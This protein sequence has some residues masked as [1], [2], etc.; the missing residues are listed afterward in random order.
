M[1]PSNNAIDVKGPESP[2]TRVAVGLPLPMAGVYDYLV[3]SDISVK[4][5]DLVTVPFGPRKLTGVVWSFRDLDVDDL[6]LDKLKYIDCQLDCSALD[7]AILK[8]VEWVAAYTLSPQG[9]ILR[10]V[11]SVPDATEAPKQK[12]DYA[13]ASSFS[14]EA[15]DLRKTAARE[16]VVALMTEQ[17]QLPQKDI[18]RRAGVGASVVKSLVKAGALEAKLRP[19]TKAFH[20][21]SPDLSGPTLAPEQDTAAGK[22]VS[23]VED[24]KFS[25]TVLDG[26]TGSGK[27][28]V[29]FEAIAAAL[30]QG[31]QVMVLLPEI[32]LTSQWLDRF[33]Q[34][35][36]VMPA[37]WHSDLNGRER[38]QC[39]RAV[40]SGEV[41]VLVGAR[42]ALFLPFPKLG[43]IIIDEEH[44]QAFKQ[45]DGVRY[46][47]RDMSV[48][49]AKQSKCPLILSSATPSMES[50][51][52]VNHGRYIRVILPR[53]FAGAKP[54]KIIPLDL[55][56]D[57]PDRGAWLAP[58]LVEAIK[59]ATERGEQSLLFLNRR[60][61]APLTLCRSCGH[62][63]ECPSCSAWLVEHRLLKKLQCHHCGYGLPLPEACPKCEEKQSLVPCG[64]G[65]ER[66]AEEVSLRFPEARA[67]VV[68]SDTVRGPVAAA[69]FVSIVER[70][71][72]D[73]L[74]GTQLISKGY[75]F[76][77]LTV[78]G[79]VDADLGL[80]GGDFRASERSFQLLQ[81]VAGRA[82]RD[83]EHPG[84]VF[85]QTH[86]PNHPVM[87]ALAANDRDAFYAA[88]A[89][90][91]AEA[92]MPP[93]GRMAALILSDTKESSVDEACA[94]LARDAPNGKGL[95]V[96]GPAPAPITL[97]RGR[98]RRRFL[99][100]ADLDNR[101]QPILFKWLSAVKLPSSVR[102]SVDIDPY[103]FL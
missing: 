23:S 103:N 41:A 61:Y 66:V 45:E 30:K 50:L 49:R 2:L 52:N 88:E 89:K 99:I 10:M 43:L 80:F 90:E 28:E 77:H 1:C 55:K 82:G 65:V 93:F 29:Y 67:M 78:V 69:E 34:R 38:R 72:V 59:E 5:G 63:L 12:L 94:R 86:D 57:V 91:R 51:N 46:H 101:L 81:Q 47:A 7:P 75:H 13:L 68:S 40:I 85:L 70:K 8:F 58:S 9:V 73:I 21:P 17:R 96:W 27:T 100:Q 42:S 60:G 56:I 92:K 6:P 37:E 36:G 74:I 11:L 97:L 32:A 79:V 31:R 44:D 83:L 16:A 15:A 54:P 48:V 76:P 98:Y 3:P 95:Q 39:W 53:R 84:K 33:K 19:I 18:E 25:V 24:N 35:F 4:P 62:R 20:W 22:L 71:E 102:L 26:V 14:W 64:P 87:C